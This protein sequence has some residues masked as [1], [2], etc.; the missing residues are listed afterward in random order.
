MVV[1]NC[2]LMNFPQQDVLLSTFGEYA[3]NFEYTVDGI[4][5]RTMPPF[6]QSCGAQMT[7]NG[8][9]TYTKKGLGNVK[10]GR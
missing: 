9:N 8:Y 7:Y 4:F 5:R 1:L 3:D 10:V 2:T 6:C